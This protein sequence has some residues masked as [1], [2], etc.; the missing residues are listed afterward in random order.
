MYTY[1]WSTSCILSRHLP[2]QSLRWGCA[3]LVRVMVLH[4]PSPGLG[5][6]QGSTALRLVVHHVVRG[7]R[8]RA[9]DEAKPKFA[10][11]RWVR[12]LFSF[13][14]SYL[15]WVVGKTQ[16]ALQQKASSTP[17]LNYAGHLIRKA[18]KDNLHVGILHLENMV[19]EDRMV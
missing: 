10:G 4:V 9:K 14:A 8:Q 1:M 17:L 5:L 11:P 18:R 2:K 19:S 12:H 15:V 16:G 13:W 7:S 6:S 3:K